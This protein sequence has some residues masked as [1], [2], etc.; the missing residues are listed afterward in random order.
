MNKGRDELP[1]NIKQDVHKIADGLSLQQDKIKALYKYMQDNTRYISVQLGIGGLQP[2]DA[3]YV[4]ANRYGDCKALSN[5][6]Q[7]ILK[8]AGIISYYSII[9]AGDGEKFYMPDFVSDQTNHIIVSVP[10]DKDTMWLECTN[11]TMAAGY[12]GSFTDD[13]Y[14]LLIKE[15]DG[16]LVKTPAY[17]RQNN[18]VKRNV[19][20]VVDGAGALKAVVRNTYTGLEQDDLHGMLHGYTRDQLLKYLKRSIDLPTYDVTNVDYKEQKDIIPVIDE[21]YDLSAPN[22]AS[23]T[24]KRL[25]VQPNILSREA[26]KLNDAEN[27]KFDIVY[28]FSFTHVDTTLI[29]VP[30]DYQV[31][32]MPKDVSIKNKLGEYELR[33]K[34]VNGKIILHRRYERSAARF[35]PAEY[36]DMAAFYNEMYK[37]DHSKVVFVKKEV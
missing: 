8:E 1:D 4:A 3:K 13:R 32:T 30:P 28:D 14:A 21:K 25:F 27:R 16:H 11:Q 35:S 5:Y 19:D 29:N 33:F 36:K 26:F 24:G 6:M 7:A 15:D 2:F 12:L 9:H 31:E 20:A 34:Y 10:L 23:A 22:Y 18:V 17:T 37:A